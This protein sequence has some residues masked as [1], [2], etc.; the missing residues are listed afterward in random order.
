MREAKLVSLEGRVAIVTGAAG[1][2]GPEYCAGLAREGARVVAA[3]IRPCDEVVATLRQAGGE[4]IGLRTDVVSAEST[5]AMAREA[6]E[7]FGRIDILINNAA[8]LVASTPFDQVDE[9]E[10][11]QV[12]AVNVKGYWQCCKA[13]VPTMRRQ[14][15]GRI[16]NI[17]SAACLLGVPGMIHYVSS[18]GAVI[19]FTR[20]LARELAGSGISVNAVTPGFIISPAARKSAGPEGFEAMCQQ[21]IDMQIVKRSEEPR[22]LVGTILF[23]A[24][25]ASEFISGQTINVD[26]GAALV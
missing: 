17:S 13:V 18:K 8:Y 21:L 4:A 22:D 2:I 12:M 19:A 14:G 10:W 1:G 23:L 6:E 11:D 25:D 26:G 5:R 3:D 15:K 9:T 16:I 20:A 7:R 24:S